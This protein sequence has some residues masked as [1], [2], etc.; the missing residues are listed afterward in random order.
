VGALRSLRPNR[1]P[2]RHRRD[3][4]TPSERIPLVRLLP[5]GPL[6]QGNQTDPAS[7]SHTASSGRAYAGAAVVSGAATEAKHVSRYGSEM[8]NTFPVTVSRFALRISRFPG[9]PVLC[10]C[11]YLSR[12]PFRV[13]VS[14]FALWFRVTVSRFAFRFRASRYPFA[15][16]FP[17]S[18]SGFALRAS[19]FALPVSFRFREQFIYLDNI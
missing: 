6:P 11:L 1:R 8:R 10:A 2:P 17:V 15:L 14:R 13:R 3:P 9:E 18:R 5:L 19:D 12:F 4:T 7:P 16:R